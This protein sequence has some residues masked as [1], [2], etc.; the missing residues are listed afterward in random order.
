MEALEQHRTGNC[1]YNCGMQMTDQM[2]FGHGDY[3]E[4]TLCHGV[5]TGTGPIEGVR[6]GHAWLEFKGLAFDF[7]NDQHKPTAI[8]PA[9]QYRRV[10]RITDIHE[11]NA[12]QVRE[13]ICTHGT[14]GPWELPEDIL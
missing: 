1:F 7:T 11:Y 13:M 2:I 4:Y 6:Y 14:W 10:G 8:V 12:A 5:A 3:Q 9:D